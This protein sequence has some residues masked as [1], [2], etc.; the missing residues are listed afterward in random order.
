[1]FGYLRFILAYA[2]MLSHI[3]VRV[4]GLNPGVMAVVVF[5]LLAGYVVSFLYRELFASR[6]ERLRYFYMDRIKRIFPLYLY[7]DR[8]SVV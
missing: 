7:V 3:G 8:K 6:Q 1:M 5:Y 2:V 4:H